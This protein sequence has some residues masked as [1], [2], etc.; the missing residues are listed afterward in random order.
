MF[1]LCLV[2]LLGAAAGAQGTFPLRYEPASPAEMPFLQAGQRIIPAQQGRAN[3]PAGVPE[4]AAGTRGFF[5]LRLGRLSRWAVYVPGSAPTLLVDT[6]G[7]RDLSDETPLP[8]KTTRNMTDFGSASVALKGGKQAGVRLTAYARE[9]GGP[10][11][12]LIIGPAGCCRGTVELGGKAYAVALVDRNL[13]GRF[14]DAFSGTFT[15]SDSLAVDLDGNGTFDRPRATQR[16]LEVDMLAKRRRVGDAFYDISVAPDGTKAAFK[17]VEPGYGTLDLGVP[18]MAWEAYSD[19]GRCQG[20]TAEDGTVRLPA[21]RY[22]VIRLTLVKK[23]DAGTEW[24][25]TM[26]GPPKA[27][28]PAVVG[29]DATARVALGEPL[30]A[31][32]DAR[33]RSATVELTLRLR[34]Q[35]GERYAAGILK[36]RGRPLPPEFEILSE[37]D[38]VL[39]TGKFEYG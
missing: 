29:P 23:D 36:G 2:G 10:P 25:L 9:E 31:E 19:Y 13:N 4:K 37:D 26:N 1:A 28:A 38:K 8:G 34:G 5:F 16:P 32:V 15:L 35:A 12:Y 11:V 39:E 20:V 6:D 24:K 22:Q 14:D 21:G 33:K 27:L 3:E 30:V 18:G 7:D 17:R